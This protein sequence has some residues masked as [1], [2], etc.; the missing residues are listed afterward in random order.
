MKETKNKKE[1]RKKKNTIIQIIR[2]ARMQQNM[3]QKELSVKSGLSLNYISLLESNM[4]NYNP[5]K[6]NLVKIARALGL[7]PEDLL[8]EDEGYLL[9]KDS[10]DTQPKSYKKEL[11]RLKKNGDISKDDYKIINNFLKK[12][13]VMN[14]FKNL[15]MGGPFLKVWNTVLTQIKKFAT[16]FT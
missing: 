11:D 10:L 12:Q 15:I 14:I 6:E 16:E 9:I 2:D 3:T 5:R 7:N 1:F 13:E 8:K 4:F